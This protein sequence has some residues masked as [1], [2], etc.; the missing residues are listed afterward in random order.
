MSRSGAPGWH[1]LGRVLVVQLT[2][3]EMAA[4]GDGHARCEQFGRIQLCERRQWPQVTFA[5]G[6]QA[7]SGRVE[8]ATVTNGGQ[9]ILQPPP[10]APMHVH[11][12]GGHGGQG[13]AGC[14]LQRVR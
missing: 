12:A 7:F 13:A 14:Q 6:K 9:Q 5:V 10:V 11:I 2:Q 1:Q 4:F 8:R 3:I